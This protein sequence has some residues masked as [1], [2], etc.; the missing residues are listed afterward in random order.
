MSKTE[1]NWTGNIHPGSKVDID[2][3]L[4]QLVHA[5]NSSPFFNYNGMSMRV[6][7]GQI[8]A[9]VE[10]QDFMIGN[11]AFQILHGGLAATVLDSVGGIVAMGELYKKAE[12]ET[13]AETIKKVSRLATVDMRVDYLAPGRGKYFIA[14]AETLR[15]GRKGCTMRM[16][17]VNDEDKAIATA[18]ASY[19]Y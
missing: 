5:F 16:T 3:V 10:M 15:L 6:V 8:E 13:I 4:N 12:P 14:R 18:I 19:A 1:R 7:E 9:Y 11:V 2:V 17:M